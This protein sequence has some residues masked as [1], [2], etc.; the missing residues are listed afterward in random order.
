V[1]RPAAPNERINMTEEEKKKML[2]EAKDY[3]DKQN[4]PFCP[5]CD[6]VRVCPT[7]GSRL[8]P[9]IYGYEPCHPGPF[10]IL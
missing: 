8:W 1:K 2:D 3:N 4:K 5:Y 6:G 10:W 9:T 7:C